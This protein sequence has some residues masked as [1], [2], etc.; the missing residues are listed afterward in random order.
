MKK[1]TL[2]PGKYSY[3]ATKNNVAA[4]AAYVKRQSEINKLQQDWVKL[5]FKK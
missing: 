2:V 3:R 1:V 5:N 4:A